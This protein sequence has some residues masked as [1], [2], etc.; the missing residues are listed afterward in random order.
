MFNLT[1]SG[2]IT[3]DA[4]ATKFNGKNGE[5]FAIKFTLAVN[6]KNA[7]GSKITTYLP[8]V[9]WCKT[10]NILPYLK[11]GTGINILINWFTNNKDQNSDRYYHEFR[12]FELEFQTGKSSNSGQV[13]QQPQQT[14]QQPFD[15]FANPNTVSGD[16]ID[17]LPF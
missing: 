5:V 8:C 7:D 10:S 1:A 2:N 6:K 16:E 13:Q 12:V 11:Q 15:R 14:Q 4:T 3:K 9:Y 17:D